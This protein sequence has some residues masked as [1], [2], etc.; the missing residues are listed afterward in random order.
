MRNQADKDNVN[1]KLDEAD[2]YIPEERSNMEL[3]IFLIGGGQL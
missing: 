1:K 3:F 2:F